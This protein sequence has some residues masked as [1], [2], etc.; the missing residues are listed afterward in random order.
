MRRTK[1]VSAWSIVAAAA[2]LLS[3][4]SGGS[5]TGS[6]PNG[7]STDVNTM[8]TGKAQTADSYKL[9]DVPA[10]SQLGKVTVGIDDAFTAYNQNTPDN[11]TSYNSFVLTAVLATP[12]VFDGDNKVL[13][14]QDVMQSVDVTSKDPQ[15]VQWKLKPNVKWS[16]GQAWSCKD[17]YLSWL[18]QSGAPKGPD[19]K[20]AFTPASSTGYSLIDT[21]SCKDP[22]TF[23]AH[24]TAPYVDYKGLFTSSWVLPAHIVEQKSGVSDITTVKPNSDPATIKKVADFWNTGWNTFDPALSP[25]S[26]PYKIDKVDT[27]QGTV[28]LSKNPLWIGAKGGPQQIVVRSI[29]DRNAMAA[30]LQNGEIDVAAS[31]QPD[32]TAAA[33]MKNL[34]GQG[35]I[36][37]SASQLSFEHLDLNYKR[38]FADPV[39]RKAFMQ[40]INRQEIADKL[41]KPVQ[42]SA[43]PL[44]SLQF[45][46]NEPGYQDLYSK[47]AGAGADAAAKTLTDA[48]WAKGPDGI[49]AKNGK[50]FEVTITHNTNA[51]RSQTVE[52][53][54]SQAKAAG[55][56]V[57]DETDPNFLKGRASAGGYDVA[58]FAWSAAPFK[59]ESASIYQ[60]G[61]EQNWQGLS[62]PKIDT[63][64]KAGVS[65]TDQAAATKAFQDADKAIADQYA[66]LPLFAI[67]SMWAFRGIDRVWMQS[68]FGALWNVGEWAK[69]G[70]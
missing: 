44:N 64:L 52:I 59:A 30:A 56:L 7:S 48:G 50:K 68:Y 35:V 8:K 20:A 29:N 27:N 17:F 42:A 16:D 41:L 24:F 40:A 4:C 18:A 13:L 12:Y 43:A 51:R 14:N 21:A 66:S 26:G 22:L 1:A 38:L 47:V 58:L 54:I 63:A 49:F 37:G 3:A 70:S 65:A 33:T 53:I 6:S 55:I 23:E 34:S 36:Y 2:L 11:N 28:T 19:G 67:P 9:A 61:G 31:T 46:P 62:D 5:G 25:S 32:A 15:V 45:Y 57:H 60:T 69:S 10:A 39:A